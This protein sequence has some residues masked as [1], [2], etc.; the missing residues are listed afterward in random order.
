VHKSPRLIGISYSYDIGLAVLY[1]W[2]VFQAYVYDAKT[3]TTGILVYVLVYGGFTFLTRSYFG[4]VLMNMLSAL[5]LPLY[6]AAPVLQ[7]A[8][9]Y[10]AFQPFLGMLITIL[11]GMI[12]GIL[13]L[14]LKLF[15]RKLL[16]Q[17]RQYIIS[18]VVAIVF[19]L[20]LSVVVSFLPVIVRP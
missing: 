9:G 15:G 7:Q 11:V 2:C 18:A 20:A 17:K 13:F 8:G 3:Q 16:A 6:F 1:A 14:P 12:Q 4:I 10:F 19:T 5:L